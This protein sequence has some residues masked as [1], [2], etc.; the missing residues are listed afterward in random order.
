MGWLGRE[1]VETMENKQES[2]Q[3][4]QALSEAPKIPGQEVNS[5]SLGLGPQL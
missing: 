4:R 1:T 2:G 3:E 5:V